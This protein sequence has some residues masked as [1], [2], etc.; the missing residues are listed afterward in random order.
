MKPS[1]CQSCFSNLAVDSRMQIFLFL[2]ENG[3]QTVSDVV[4][5]FALS[6]PT[7]SYHLKN[8]EAAKLLSKEK[9]GKVTYY[10]INEHCPNNN[11]A[12]LLKQLDFTN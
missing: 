1:F 4:K 9:S 12:C 10:F 3:R 7:I 2:K 8:M 11:K 6:Q 5:H